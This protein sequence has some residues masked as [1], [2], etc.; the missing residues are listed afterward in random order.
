MD[1]FVQFKDGVVSA[2]LVIIVLV[3]TFLFERA[4][5]SFARHHLR[6]SSKHMNIGHRQFRA[7]RH[8]F[9]AIIYLVGIG[10]AI[11]LIPPLRTLSVSLFA[12][13]GILAIVIGF[14]SQKA[15]ANL[16]GG[17]YGF[18][19]IENNHVLPAYSMT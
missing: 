15:L 7:L 3:V 5:R 13:A 18:L 19:H 1:F 11:Y 14:A 2:A 16:I 17:I 6:K 9:S 8:F 10:V 4:V 12:S